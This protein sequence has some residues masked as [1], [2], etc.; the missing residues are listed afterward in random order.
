[1]KLPITIPTPLVVGILVFLVL[2]F[3]GYFV[4][5]TQ[6]VSSQR[7]SIFDPS[8]T[9]G[10]SVNAEGHMSVHL[11]DGGLPAFTGPLG[12]R[13]I[14]FPV[15]PG[16]HPGECYGAYTRGGGSFESASVVDEP[17]S[18]AGRPQILVR[19]DADPTWVEDGQANSSP[20]S[21]SSGV[22]H[23]GNAFTFGYPYSLS[24]KAFAGVM[25]CW[26]GSG[27]SDRFAVQIT[28]ANGGGN[29]FQPEE[30]TVQRHGRTVVWHKLQ[31]LPPQAYE[32][33]GT[34]ST[35]VSFYE[36]MSKSILFVRHQHTYSSPIPA[37]APPRFYV[38]ELQS[39]GD[40]TRVG[41]FGNWTG[42]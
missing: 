21:P 1:M 4:G 34:G 30:L 20:I 7:V 23:T 40:P 36:P 19:I 15:R 16:L 11:A 39:S 25:L 28:L 42:E 5:S 26:H 35:T 2:L 37:N 18:G 24:F 27:V 9:N 6:A 13:H 31:G 38:F 29:Q 8:G 14:S 17:G 10:V 22:A 33:M 41:P 32:L 3:G 12:N